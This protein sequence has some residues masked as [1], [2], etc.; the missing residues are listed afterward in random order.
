[1]CLWHWPMLALSFLCGSRARVVGRSQTI[2]DGKRHGLPINPVSKGTSIGPAFALS[3]WLKRKRVALTL[4]QAH[5]GPY[6]DIE[7]FGHSAQ[8]VCALKLDTIGQ[9]AAVLSSSLP[10]GD[11]ARD[12]AGGST[13]HHDRKRVYAFPRVGDGGML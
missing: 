3:H 9:D 8:A 5:N 2:V 4:S 1:M 11:V 6:C 7:R 10:L 12:G 13:H